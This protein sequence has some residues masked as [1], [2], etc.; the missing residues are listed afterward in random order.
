MARNL[1]TNFNV[2]PYFDDYDENKKFLRI[3]FRPGFPVQARELTQLQTILQNQVERF[4]SSIYEDGTVVV[5]SN[6]SLTDATYIKLDDGSL[7]A[8]IDWD[9]LSTLISLKNEGENYQINDQLLLTNG[10]DNIIATFGANNTFGLSLINSNIPSGFFGEILTTNFNATVGATGAVFEINAKISLNADPTDDR[11]ERP[12]FLVQGFTTITGSDPPTLFGQYLTGTEFAAGDELFLFDDLTETY[13]QS[14]GTLS[15]N[16]SGDCQ[17]AS[18]SNGIFY[19]NGFFVL[20]SPQ[21]IPYS[22]Y[23]TT[24]SARVGFN[25]VESIVVESDD[26]SLLDNAAGSPNEN[27]PGAHRF[28]IDLIL[29]AKDMILGATEF[30]NTTSEDFYEIGRVIEGDIVDRR[31]RPEFSVL[32]NEIANRTYDINGDFVINDFKMTLERFKVFNMAV[33]SHTQGST[34]VD[35]DLT[36]TTFQISD[37]IDKTFTFDDIP[38]RI[39]NAVQ[40]GLNLNLFTITVNS[41]PSFLTLSGTIEIF[42]NNLYLAELTPGKAYIAGRQLSTTGTT[43]LAL[44][45]TR[46]DRH[47]ESEEDK[48]IN[49]SFGNYLVLDPS[50]ATVGDLTLT[51]VT[52]GSIVNFYSD[53]NDNLQIGQAYTRQLKKSTND[54]YELYFFNASFNTTTLATTTNT[55]TVGTTTLLSTNIAVEHLGATF[56][57]NGTRYRIIAVNTGAGEA[58]L[59]TPLTSDILPSTTLTLTYNSLNIKAVEFDDGGIFY[60]VVDS[61]QI[62]QDGDGYTETIVQETNKKPLIFNISDTVAKDLTN[63]EYTY[64]KREALQPDGEVITPTLRADETLLNNK[65]EVLIY[66]QTESLDIPASGISLVDVANGEIRL[67]DNTYDTND[68]VI[69]YPVRRTLAQPINTTVAYGNRQTIN[70]NLVNQTISLDTVTD[71]QAR[72]PVDSIPAAGQYISIGVSFAVRVKVFYDPTQGGAA[73]LP[74]NDLSNYTDITNRFFIDFGQREDFVDHTRIALKP[75]VARPTSGDDIIVVFDRINTSS[76]TELERTFYSIDSYNELLYD[77]LPL[78]KTS[79]N[80]SYDLRKTVDF[81]PRAI[82]YTSTTSFTE[83]IE[84]DSKVYVPHALNN[85]TFEC[86]VSYYVARRDKVVI[87]NDLQFRVLQGIPSLTPEYPQL[88]DRSL[89][90][91]D[92]TYSPYSTTASDVEKIPYRHNRYTMKDISEID[93]RLKIL[94]DTVRLDKIE[95]AILQTEV[96]D[97]DNVS[98]FKTGVLVDT[99][100]NQDVSNV[101]SPDYKAAID[102]QRGEMRAQFD[103]Y[104]FSMEYDETS[105]N[106]TA[107][108]TEDG[109]LLSNYDDDNP[110]P[111]VTQTVATRT[112]NV[113]PFAV[114]SWNGVITL[115][116]SKDFWKDIIRAPDV[117]SNISGT[118]E[119][120]RLLQD[121]INVAPSRT[122]WNNWETEWTSTASDTVSFQL[123]PINIGTASFDRELTAEVVQ[124]QQSQ[125]RTGNTQS[126]SF[127]SKSQSLGERVIDTSVIPFMRPG[128]SIAFRARSIKPNTIFYPFFDDE[129]VSSNIVSAVILRVPL[130]AEL[131][132]LFST[133]SSY[134]DRQ[135]ALEATPVLNGFDVKILKVTRTLNHVN[136]HLVPK[137]TQNNFRVSFDSVSKTGVEG[138]ANGTTYSLTALP[139]LVGSI[140]GVLTQQYI[141]ADGTYRL[142]SDET[143]AVCGV[144]TIPD[145]GTQF[146]TGKRRFKLT[147][148]ASNIDI[149]S[150]STASADF[151]SEGIQKTLQEQIITTRVPVVKNT[152]VQESRI[153]YGE[154]KIANAELSTLGGAFIFDAPKSLIN[155]FTQQTLDTS[156][157]P[158]TGVSSL[159]VS[160]VPTAVSGSSR[161]RT[162]SGARR[163]RVRWK[164]PLAQTFLIDE[165]NYPS[166]LYLHS[167]DLWFTSRDTTVP[168]TLQIRPVRNGY[169]SSTEVMP[170]GEVELY[171]EEVVANDAPAIENYTRFKFSTPIYLTPGEYS[172]VVL[173]NTTNY[174]VYTSRIGERVIDPNTGL[175]TSRIQSKQPYA[176]VMF[177][178]QNSS[179]WTAYQEE[180]MMFRLN[181]VR[182]ETGTYTGDFY[183]DFDNTQLER[184][185]SFKTEEDSLYF[186]YDAALTNSYFTYNLYKVNVPQI[187]DFTDDIEP[188]YSV[189]RGVVAPDGVTVNQDSTY[190]PLLVN[191]NVQAPSL[192]K[193][194]GGLLPSAAD[195]RVRVSFGT[196]TDMISPMIDAEQM[197]VIFVQNIIDNLAL[198]PENDITI[199]AGGSGYSVADTF[200]LQDPVTGE[201]YGT[202]VPTTSNV[203]E[204]LTLD[205]GEEAIRVVRKPNLVPDVVTGSGLVVTI[206]SEEDSSGGIASS[207]YVSRRVQLNAGFESRDLKVKMDVLRPQGTQVYVYYKVK[208]SEDPDLFET[209][210]WNLMYESTNPDEVSIGSS[211][212]LPLEF[213]TFDRLSDNT[214]RPGTNGGARYTSNNIVYDQF[215]VYAIK[216]VLA[217]ET[218][219]RTPKVK[220]LGALALIN[221]IQP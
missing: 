221:A 108:I 83:D 122:K 12:V 42:D 76:P 151:V 99:F 140:S 217:S 35:V 207:K 196:N 25:I 159:G 162:L 97:K 184:L 139:N 68:L 198:N 141:P 90:L 67:V 125:R 116:P 215:N 22:K 107:F 157:L 129:N 91:Y 126:F 39:T 85:S 61:I 106:S 87:T 48:L 128:L 19:T 183:A 59:D 93:E 169:P 132:T 34:S 55:S 188:E 71:N 147:D 143:G 114:I 179:T 199:E 181:R 182:F 148:Q 69:T 212:Y 14:Y 185:V 177:K 124:S 167:V 9:T 58:T 54:K 1:T 3:L 2:S 197:N 46:T 65:F 113:N 211:D 16:F 180:D 53:V 88:E 62:D 173:T 142:K 82:N 120:Y 127:E 154:R 63:I 89:V 110:F 118:N 109:I 208:A 50:T 101:I 26:N 195:F 105:V 152:E 138:L 36:L 130:T 200:L 192:L 57:F 10:T 15:A 209:K 78:I 60:D 135:E 40:D 72:I 75:G 4:G 23:T 20:V 187:R 194:R 163:G 84:F 5:G 189:I 8:P 64:M 17:L 191:Q 136:F 202:L 172:F 149:Q 123:P 214:I 92:V 29:D 41:M 219:L 80:R 153:V 201:S 145:N 155:Q 13:S 178:S 137:F 193:I 81:R 160:P 103:Q 45:K 56:T 73:V 121:Q 11:E 43:R 133:N 220:N 96:T 51:D 28:K 49:V 168:V 206:R 112:E 166:G 6:L 30:D 47:L 70:S 218:P 146:K 176:G 95:N 102:F 210:P 161:D 98:L 21:T 32:G 164:D 171:P 7:S 165:G 150:K 104:A 170:F 33:V 174:E 144:F 134:F 156:S 52:L 205:T 37:L 131:R 115:D 216:V 117:V 79:S 86:D 38:F 66:N 213:V 111:F 204:G 44:E 190:Q 27:A 94:E 158:Q 186:N 74:E 31:E 175:Q 100:K 203:V 18:V 77:F 119:A 24:R